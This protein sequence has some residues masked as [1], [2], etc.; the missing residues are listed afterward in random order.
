MSVLEEPPGQTR[1]DACVRWAISRIEGQVFRPGMKLP[2]VRALARQRGVSPF[3]VVEAYERLVAQGYAEARRGSGFYVLP[4]RPG[5]RLQPASTA[6]DFGWLLRHM[7]QGP[8][9]SGPGVG[10]LPA[11]W[12]DG[13]RIGAAVRALGREGPSHWLRPGEAQG[14]GPL[15]EVLQS[16][17]ASLEIPATPDQIVLTTGITQGLDLVLRTLVGPGETVLCLDPFWFGALGS[18]TAHGAHV[19]GVPMRPDGPDPVL[20]EQIAREARP[21]LFILSTVGHNPT[22]AAFS[23]EIAAAVLEIARR[24]DFHIFEDD[25]YADLC[26]TPVHRLAAMDE[27]ERVIYAGSFSKTLASNVRVGFLACA[28]SLASRLVDAKVLS[29]FT[30]PELNERLAHKLLVEG[31]FAGHA[32]RLR[33]R[34]GKRRDATR[35][36]LEAAGVPVFGQP[37]E[38]MF[39]WVDMGCDTNHLAAICGERGAL[40]APGAL[41]SPR[42]RPSSWMRL[43]VTTP[44]AEIASTLAE[45]RRLASAGRPATD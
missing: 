20:L 4:R 39:L 17:L 14:F 42:Q 7:L 16:R 31:R 30:T 19:V 2:S 36:Q 3:T 24:R 10:V 25:V 38:G 11:S 35:A 33:E 13:A 29:G 1:V 12:L 21:R 34:L 6:I 9:A 41:F 27:L 18:A 32:Q 37:R 44:P 22:G 28:P 40:V 23:P 8:D 43:N 26:E 5:P 15:R 45:A